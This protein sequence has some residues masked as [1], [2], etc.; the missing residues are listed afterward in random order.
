MAFMRSR[1]SLRRDSSSRFLSTEIFGK[2]PGYDPVNRK[3]RFLARLSI[4]VLCLIILGLG[5]F[6]YQ[7]HVVIPRQQQER[8]TAMLTELSSGKASSEEMAANCLALLQEWPYADM[9]TGQQERFREV[10]KNL[11]SRCSNLE[12]GKKQETGIY[13]SEE[14]Q[15]FLDAIEAAGIDAQTAKN[16]SLDGQM[17]YLIRREDWERAIDI[18][19]FYGDRAAGEK[20]RERV[21]RACMAS[22]DKEAESFKDQVTLAHASHALSWYTL[23]MNAGS[24]EA[25][26]AFGTFFMK[27]LEEADAQLE[28]SHYKM[29]GDLYRMLQ[30]Y[31][32]KMSQNA[33]KPPLTDRLKEISYRMAKDEMAEGK[34]SVSRKSFQNVGKYKDALELADECAYLQAQSLASDGSYIQAAKL[35]EEISGYKDA[36]DL[37]LKA[38]YDYCASVAEEPTDNAYDYLEIL[39]EA[40]YP[41]ID[42]VK[43][44]IYTLHAKIETG[45]HYLMGSEQSAYIR[46]T[47][48]GGAPDETTHIR[49]E[50]VDLDDGLSYSWTSEEEY[51]RGEKCDSVYQT[52]SPLTGKTIFDKQFKVDV[53]ADDGSHLGSWKGQFSMEF[54]KD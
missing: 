12:S 46:T 10:A 30:E 28:E 47:L 31:E 37:R 54:L 32:G 50:L 34:Y 19:R 23:M 35:Y 36:D 25:G 3:H 11:V 26:D 2:I 17:Q 14:G 5:T 45:M 53:Y 43:D 27:V 9:E 1:V 38:A 29:A 4:P 52:S 6:L 33:I 16:I 8:M 48:I 41:G 13:L 51:K 40:D 15:E 49:L 20:A 7:Q 21:T 24:E 18:L 39:I 22:A 44:E 42:K